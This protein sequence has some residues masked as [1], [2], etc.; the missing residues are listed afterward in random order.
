LLLNVALV[1]A[2]LAG[3]YVGGHWLVKGASRLAFSFGIST[4]VIGL[5]V[6]AWATSAPELV[7]NIQAALAES[8]D[9]VLGNILGSNIANVGLALSLMGILFV[10][11]IGWQLTIREIPIMLGASVLLYV[12]AMDGM[13]GQTDGV[14]L[15]GGFFGFSALVYYLAQRERRQLA[16]DLER[17]EREEGLVSPRINRWFEFG[18]LAAGALALIV[19]ADF[20]ID[21]ATALADAIGVSEFVIGLTLVAV[22]TSLPEI[23]ASLVAGR[24]G[25]TDI[26]VGNIVGSNIS[27]ILAVLGVTTIIHP[28]EVPV[29]EI[30]PDVLVMLAFSMSLLL[31]AVGHRW[32]RWVAITLLIAY[33][34][35]IGMTFAS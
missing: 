16:R 6:V 7:V 20:T 13:L 33:I 19:A 27:N 11:R 1:I 22:G 4:L 30:Q 10:V 34:A 26:A 31:L 24:H 5:T 9:I 29:Q 25:E 28:I 15:F 32:R 8:T 21:G 23:A 3:L 12:L 2:G 14:L 17:Y 35:Y 18:R